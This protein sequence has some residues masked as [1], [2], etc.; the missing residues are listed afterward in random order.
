ERR[1]TSK[2]FFAFNVTMQNH[3]GYDFS[4]FTPTVA[5]QGY[6]NDYPDVE[7][8]LS[9]AKAS[10][11]AFEKLTEY[12]KNVDEPTIICMFGDHLPKVSEAFYA[13]L[14]GDKLP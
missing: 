10:D 4:P 1:D 14:M 12:F 6:N 2:P 11:A 7:Q 9:M 3:G 13:E 5:L 8:Y